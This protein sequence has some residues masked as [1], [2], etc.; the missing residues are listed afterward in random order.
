M[1]SE[2][3]DAAHKVEKTATT[4]IEDLDAVFL[5]VLDCVRLGATDVSPRFFGETTHFSLP[6]GFTPPSRWAATA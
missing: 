3:R 2:T 1:A 5:K 4:R 6:P